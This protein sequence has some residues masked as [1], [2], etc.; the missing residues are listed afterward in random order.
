[1]KK[2]K[3]E[4]LKPNGFAWLIYRVFSAIFMKIK[5]NVK[6]DRTEFNARNK[7]EGCVVLYNHA[8]NYDHYI[9]TAFFKR[10]KVNYVIS[11]RFMFNPLIRF[12]LKL[13]KAIHRDQ[14]KNDTT[15]ILKMKRV[16]ERGGVIAIAPAGQVSI[17]GNMPYINPV[18]VK[19]LK[20]C[21]ADVYTLQ[22][23][24]SYLAAPKWCLS[25]RKYPISVKCVKTLSKEDIKLLD[26]DTI[27]SKVINDLNLSDRTYQKD[28]LIQIKGKNLTSGL[29]NILFMCPKCGKKYSFKAIDNSLV[30]NDCGNTVIYNKYGFLEKTK[31][32][33]VILDDEALWCEYQKR[34]IMAQIKAKTYRLESNV[35]FYSN[36]NKEFKLE[37]VGC[38]KLIFDID[39]LKYIGTY[40]GEEII[41]EFNLNILTQ[42]P[43]SPNVRFNI[44]DD[45]GMLEFVPDNKQEVFEWA[46]C[47]DAY[48]TLKNEEKEDAAC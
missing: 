3:K 4:N 33:D 6:Y 24:G 32:S 18:I 46:T 31:D 23:T 5:F 9:S 8:C 14:F 7:K 28:A 20:M 25:K 13:V 22:T 48:H 36:P 42:F 12:V 29:E 10:T 34:Q 16:I 44:P 47:I 40:L 45:E 19:L 2:K 27:Y 43:F 41:K 38:G 39:S 35:S 30:C 11:N 15:S 1:M 17:H 26:S 37:L 21:K